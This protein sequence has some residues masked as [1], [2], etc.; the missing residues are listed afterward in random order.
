[1][2]DGVTSALE[3]GSERIIQENT[4]GM[5]RGFTVFIIAYRLT[6][7]RVTNLIVM[8]DDGSLVEMA[9]ITRCWRCAVGY[10]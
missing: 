4:L 1:M 5:C 3:G 2:R 9:A 6:S 7:G 10:A 8:S